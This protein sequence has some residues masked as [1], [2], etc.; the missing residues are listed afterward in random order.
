MINVDPITVCGRRGRLGVLIQIQDNVMSI[1]RFDGEYIS[2]SNP[3]SIHR[4]FSPSHRNGVDS[5][6]QQLSLLQLLT[7][8]NPFGA[9][10]KKLNVSHAYWMSCD[11]RYRCNALQTRGNIWI[12]LCIGFILSHKLSQTAI[13][14][15]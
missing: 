14:L 11:N 6:W 3:E 7:R 4:V 8:P 15:T 9:N 10:I 2:T 12:S 13:Y 1:N 5:N